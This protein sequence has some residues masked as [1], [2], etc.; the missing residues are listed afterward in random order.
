M[1]RG[2]EIN[3]PVADEIMQSSLEH[4]LHMSVP[5]RGM[6]SAMNSS[7][8]W[9]FEKARETGNRLRLGVAAAA[10]QANALSMSLGESWQQ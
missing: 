9:S 1:L 3:L 7:A 5:G 6:V 4:I 8:L 2:S 10:P